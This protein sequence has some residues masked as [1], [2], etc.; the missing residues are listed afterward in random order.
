MRKYFH[1]IE[2]SKKG[3]DQKLARIETSN[4][5][6]ADHVRL[7]LAYPEHDVRYVMS[8]EEEKVFN[9]LPVLT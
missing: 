9:H 4:S 8:S 1:Y 5:A 6:T 2:I 3:E 7:K